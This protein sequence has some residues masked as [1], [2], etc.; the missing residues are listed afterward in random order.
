MDGTRDA[1]GLRMTH[2]ESTDRSPFVHESG[3]AQVD[4]GTQRLMRRAL[5]LVLGIALLGVVFSGVLT[6]HDLTAATAEA[7]SP[8]G[9]PGT[10]FGQP[11]CIYGLAMYSVI[12][13]IA[14]YALLR[15]RGR[16]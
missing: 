11:P 14:G 5:Q 15:T 12:A 9:P 1:E 2:Y 6:Y 3:R 8:L 16:A 10:L 7:C 13:L 4:D